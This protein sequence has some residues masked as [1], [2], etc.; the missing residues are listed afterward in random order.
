M[1]SFLRIVALIMVVASF[2]SCGKRALNPSYRGEDNF[3]QFY[4]VDTIEIESP[5]YVS[6]Y[7]G[8]L[9]SGFYMNEGDLNFTKEINLE[10][11]AKNPRVYF[12]GSNLFGFFPGEV[13][14][15]NIAYCTEVSIKE[16][17]KGI[18]ISVPKKPIKRFIL[19]LTTI[20]HYN[21]IDS[22]LESWI[23]ETDW[24]K[25]AYIKVV[26]PLCD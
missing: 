22:S 19:A 5:V 13:A 15:E 24:D 20:S 21:R 12:A 26:F 11:I 18:T 7:K 14:I 16:V 4:V 1:V 23:L 8:G 10:N 3:K 9:S 6:V 17:R 2:Y 25:S